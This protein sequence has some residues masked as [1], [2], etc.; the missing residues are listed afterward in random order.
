MPSV[1]RAI[2]RSFSGQGTKFPIETIVATFVFTTLAYFHTIH[3]I[4]HS[5]FFASPTFSQALRPTNALLAAESKIWVAVPDEE[6]PVAE[7][8][9][10]V[11]RRERNSN[12]SDAGFKSSVDIMVNYLVNRLQTQDGST[13]AHSLCYKVDSECFTFREPGSLTLTFKPGVREAWATAL[14]D[15]NLPVGPLG[16]RFEVERPQIDSIAE[17]RSGKCVA[18][19]AGALVVR[20]WDLAKVNFISMTAYMHILIHCLAS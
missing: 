4:K 15:A 3:A 7:L 12:G 11:F 5:G 20:F 18:H 13:Y 1:A 16:R 14:N 6:P 10:L 9:Q 19:A 2:V 17:M 8:L